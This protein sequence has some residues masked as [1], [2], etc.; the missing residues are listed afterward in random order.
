MGAGFEEKTNDESDD[1]TSGL[2]PKKEYEFRAI[3]KHPLITLT[4][5]DTGITR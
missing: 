1:E 2:E 5:K 4:G 3:V